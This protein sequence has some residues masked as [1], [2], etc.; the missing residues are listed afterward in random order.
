MEDDVAKR[1]GGLPGL[2]LW[3]GVFVTMVCIA[4]LALSGWREWA[5]RE[6]ALKNA[7]VDMANLARSLTQHAEDTVELADATLMGLANR[8]ETNGTDEAALAGV[9]SFLDL[10]GPTLGR[11]RGLFIY[12]ETG[13][14]LATTEKISLTGLNNSDRAYFQH[15]R[16]VDDRRAY[17]GRP[18]QSRSG[19]QWIITVSRRF[20]HTDGSFAGVVLATIDVE[21]FAQ[22]YT[23]FDIGPNGAVSLLDTNGILL[24]R[25][26]DYAAHVGRDLS[27]TR[28]IR[29][30]IAGTP[31]DAYYFKSP[32][33]GLR[34]LSFY[35]VSQRFPLLVLAT[36]AQEDVLARWRQGALARMAFVFGLTLLIGVIG[37]HLVRQLVTRQ[38]MAAALAAKE[39]DFRLLAEESS[40]MVTRIG[41]D[42]RILYAS[43][44]SARVLGWPPA[45]LMGT[46]ALAGI[47]PEDLPRVEQTIA[48]LKHGQVQEARILYRNRH[49]E[50][51]EIWIETTLRATRKSDTGMID[52]VVALSRDMTEHKDLQ[53]KLAALA[54]SDGLT[55]LAN[56]RC[57]DERLDQEWARARREG[58]PLSLLMIDIDHFKQFNDQYGHQAGD[59]CLRAVA[60]VLAAQIL[61]P[62]DLVARYGGEEFALLLPSTDAD[63]CE[64]VGMRIREALHEIQIKDASWRVTASLGGATVWPNSGSADHTSLVEAAD[65]ALYAAKS[66][67]RD[68]LIMSGQVVKWPHAKS[69]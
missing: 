49:R 3:A 12:D 32:L 68:C 4:I 13:R 37:I 22:Y 33:D 42:E 15:H 7:E 8:L 2:P 50:R 57:F 28:L 34:R 52:G 16:D 64:Q 53:A 43:P 29:E 19:G 69:A 46:P 10:R 61:R 11:I 58:I 6:T 31:A 24:A 66:G 63:G 60:G 51:S 65:R 35:R 41:F 30:R 45:R 17:L 36:Q 14:W 55:G 1:A 44:S 59:S 67:G 27:A 20:N 5:S 25:S 9:R 56:R 40:D 26:I 48:S 38:R 21:Y 62:S 54:A 47:N 23:Q 18:V 39:A